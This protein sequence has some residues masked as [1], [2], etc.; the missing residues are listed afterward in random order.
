MTLI[1][2]LGVLAAAFLLVTAAVEALQRRLRPV[3]GCGCGG[4]CRG[5]QRSSTGRQRP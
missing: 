3:E 5:R 1:L 4:G 2:V